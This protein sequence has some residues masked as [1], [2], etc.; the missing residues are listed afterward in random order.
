[1]PITDSDGRVV[2]QGRLEDS[3]VGYIEHPPGKVKV[4][5]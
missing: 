5:T 1:M 3:I 4:V 2:T